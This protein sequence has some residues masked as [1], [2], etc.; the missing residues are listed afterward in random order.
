MSSSV[1]YNVATLFIKS[2]ILTFYLRFTT[3]RVLRAV[4]YVVMA[5][6]IGYSLT[7]AFG[8][9]YLCQP[10]QAYWGGSP[11]TCLD[12]DTWFLACSALNVFTDVLILLL[13]IWILRPLK[14]GF[15]QKAAVT[16]IL[17][18]GGL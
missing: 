16:C 8:F 13:P 10:I 12:I 15:I 17:M 5:I 2:S 6:A 18:A 9:L 3:S 4:I 11:G 1:T 14:M 7:G